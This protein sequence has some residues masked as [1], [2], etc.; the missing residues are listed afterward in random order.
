MKKISLI[1]LGL[2]LI[3]A[4]ASYALTWVPSPDGNVSGTPLL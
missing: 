1:V 4:P 3:L 2:I